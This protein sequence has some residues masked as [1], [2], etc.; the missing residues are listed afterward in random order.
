[1]SYIRTTHSCYFNKNKDRLDVFYCVYYFKN[2]VEQKV[3]ERVKSDVDIQTKGEGSSSRKRW[4][5]EAEACS[6]G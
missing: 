4:R 2:N 6:R 1:V 5:K 3:P